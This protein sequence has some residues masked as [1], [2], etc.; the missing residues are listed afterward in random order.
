MTR[1]EEDIE[2]PRFQTPSLRGENKIKIS[3]LDIHDNNF[4][5]LQDGL[6]W[7]GDRIGERVDLAKEKLED[8]GEAISGTFSSINPFD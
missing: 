2:N 1:L 3:S 5:G 7:A 4:L 8:M 6:D